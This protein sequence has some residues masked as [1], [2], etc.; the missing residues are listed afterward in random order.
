MPVELTAVI[1]TYNEEQHIARCIESLMPVAARIVVV[2]SF[3]TDRTVEIACDLG[4]DVFQNPFRHQA[5]QYQWAVESCAITTDFTLR[6]DADEYLEPELQA[7][8]KTFLSAPGAVNAVYLRRKI[9]FLGRPITHGFFYPAMI[10]RLHRT[11]QGRMEQRW[12]DEH[13][14]VENA[15]TVELSGDL[16]DDNL[17]PLSW[18][19]AKHVNYARREAYEIIASRAR[20][21]SEAEALSGQA[22]RKRWLK[23]NIYGR[24]PV[25]LRSTLYFLYRYLFG[26]GFL[27]GKEGFFFHFLQAYWYRTY[28]DASLFEIERQAAAEGLS[29]YD[30]LRRDGIL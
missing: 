17:N 19:T 25:A 29:A 8:I 22:R 2:D 13:I 21:Q 15:V 6:V 26:R 18:W 11:G 12:M 24:M 30:M 4:A 7:A 23:E 20:V 5:Q 27:D 14:V 3:S 16:V 1:L 28:V 10:L 9:T